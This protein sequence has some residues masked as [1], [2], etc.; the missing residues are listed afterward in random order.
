MLLTKKTILKTTE[1]QTLILDSFGYAAYKLWN[2][3]NYEKRNYKTLGMEQFPDWYEQKKRLK[4]N[5]FYKNLP[6]QTAQEILNKLQQSWKSFFALSKKHPEK[7]PKPPR[8]KQK[9]IS[10]TFLKDAII[11]TENDLRL[12]IPKQLKSYLKETYNLNDN[13]LYLKIKC[14]SDIQNIKQIQCE[15]VDDSH[16]MI[17][18]IYEIEDMTPKD[19]NGRY[20]SIDLGVGNL[21][22]CYDSI[23][24]GFIV[25]GNRYLSVSHYFDKKIAHLQEIS[26]SMQSTKG[27]KY[28]KKTKQILRL[29]TKKRQSVY[30]IVH[31]ATKYITDYCIDNHINTVVI[32]DITNIRKNNTLG[33]KNNQTFHSLPFKKIYDK[34]GYKLALNGI[35][36][37]KQKE[38]YSSQCSPLTKTVCKKLAKKSNRKY[39]GLYV[40]NRMIY[41]ADMVGAFNILRLFYQS[42]SQ[43][44][45]FT[46]KGLSNPVKVTV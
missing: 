35:T 45:V 36:L 1:S 43:P 27:I 33:H 13:Y 19:N 6:S 11:H 24:K 9:D 20:L 46:P 3:A 42:T 37:V 15:K 17:L 2:I 38:A 18:C 30:D 16:Y 4:N 22:T 41:N 21:M 32:G 14:F 40:D 26:D 25:S 5:F 34:L 29:Y 28:S 12:S 23:G 31:K 44:F 8:F 7:N 39:R 10:F